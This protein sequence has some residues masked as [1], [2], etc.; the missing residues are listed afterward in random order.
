MVCSLEIGRFHTY[1]VH[2]TH[3][4]SCL[5]T[6]GS[7]FLIFANKVTHFRSVFP[8]VT[9]IWPRIGA[10][11]EQ[12]IDDEPAKYCGKIS[13]FRWQNRLC[14]VA[15]LYRGGTGS[16]TLL[17]VMYSCCSCTHDCCCCL[18]VDSYMTHD[19]CLCYGQETTFLLR[20][21]SGHHA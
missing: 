2:V 7:Y 6:R 1:T 15:A 13:K 11:R 19:H 20:P 16:C 18:I 10:K 9:Q 4:R 3:F 8:H 17:G 14:L 5:Q 12:N 21:Q